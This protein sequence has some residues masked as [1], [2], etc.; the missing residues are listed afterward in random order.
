[1]NSA[2]GVSAYPVS[3]RWSVKVKWVAAGRAPPAKK[4][5]LCLMSTPAKPVSWAPGLIMTSQ[6]GIFTCNLRNTP[7]I[8]KDIKNIHMM[9]FFSLIQP[10]SVYYILAL[11]RK[12]CTSYPRERKWEASI[13]HTL[14]FSTPVSSQPLPLSHIVNLLPTWSLVF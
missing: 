7:G 8:I 5:N 12:S 6:V 11:H 1:M 14:L 2:Y 4:M 13:Y 3:F 10:V 9:D